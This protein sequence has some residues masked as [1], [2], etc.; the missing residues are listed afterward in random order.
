MKKVTLL[1]LNTEGKKFI[2]NDKK[3]DTSTLQ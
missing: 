2:I 3:I 1:H